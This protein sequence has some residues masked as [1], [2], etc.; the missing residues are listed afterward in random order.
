MAVGISLGTAAVCSLPS[1]SP[2]PSCGV[3]VALGLREGLT[4]LSV[5]TAVKVG[6]L[7]AVWL[8]RPRCG[9]GIESIGGNCFRCASPIAAMTAIGLFASESA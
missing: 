9:D 6:M 4:V 7:D 1:R 5:G 8:G 3:V 2:E